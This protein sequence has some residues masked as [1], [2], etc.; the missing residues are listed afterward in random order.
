MNQDE[1]LIKVGITH[2]DI[3]GIGYEVIIKALEDPA[4]LD[5]FTPVIYGSAKIWAYYR[6][7]MGLPAVNLNIVDS[8]ADA[9]DGVIN[10]VNVIPEDTR[11][12][13][14]RPSDTSGAAA[15]AALQAA[16]ADARQ[17]DVD[18]LVTAPINKST[19]QSDEFHFPGH[20]EY[21]ESTLGDGA[22]ALMIL[23]NDMVR[24]ALCTTHLPIS[25]ISGAL[26]RQLVAEKLQLFSDSLKA[27]FGVH[28]PRIAVLALNPHCGDSGLLGSEETEII[29]PAIEDARAKKIDA[30]G[31]YAADGFFG[32]AHYRKFDGVL[33]MYHDQGL[34]P[35]KALGMDSGVNLTAGLPIVRTSP[36]HG[37]AHDIAGKNMADAQSMRCAIYAA[38]DAVRNRARE[39]A[40]TADPLPKLYVERGRDNVKLNLE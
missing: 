15:R 32:A 23:C 8:A 30:F 37:T 7:G 3:N 12:E 22:K 6:R 31:P 11:V 19:T 9:R 34:A 25:G 18:V 1:R 29:A 13:P 40:A 35:L 21:L 38:I 17:G 39:A 16:V 20:T 5:L 33:A 26:S 2:G 27:D 4:M 36:D 28:H 10:I 14:G 24:V